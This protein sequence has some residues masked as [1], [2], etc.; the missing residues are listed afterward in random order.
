MYERGLT[1]I[2]ERRNDDLSVIIFVFLG[3]HDPELAM[4]L[5]NSIA[6]LVSNGIR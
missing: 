5:E 6:Q 1:W 3:H 4:N 2:R